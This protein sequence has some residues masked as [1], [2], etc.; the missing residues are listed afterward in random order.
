MVRVVH[1]EQAEISMDYV[2]QPDGSTRNGSGNGSELRPAA[3]EKLIRV[4][5]VSFG[6][7]CVL[8]A[9]ANVTLRLVLHTQTS[10]KNVTV[11]I[12]KLRRLYDQYFQ[13][14]WVYLHPSFYYIS[15]IK[16]SWQ[17]SR[18]DCLRRGADLVIINTKEEQDFTRQFQRLT[19]IGLRHK[20]ITHQWTWVD[21]TPLTKRYWG[22]GEPNSYGGK[23]EEC[24]EIRFHETED[25]WNDIPCIDQN[26]WI[27][28]K[29]VTQI[30]E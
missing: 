30:I 2:N 7:L 19:W 6:L 28:E 17:A 16:K 1:R 26:V 23:E 10:D 5:A 22:P 8:Q 18:D 15:S 14:G 29:N 4:V 12:D 27:C 21:G 3:G 11:D 20:M 13:Q 9:A 25:S 24:V